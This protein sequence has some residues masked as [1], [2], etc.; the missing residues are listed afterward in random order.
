MQFRQLSDKDWQQFLHWAAL[1]NWRVSFQEQR[2]FQNQWRPYLFA[3]YSNGELCGFV[4]AVAY[5]ESGWIGNLLVPVEQRGK[6]YGSA[7]F[8]HA[9][10]FL[11]QAQPKRIWL[12]ASQSGQPMYER[13]GFEVVD[14]VDR[15][16]TQGQGTAESTREKSVAALVDLDSACWGESRSPLLNALS[17][18]SSICQTGNAVGLLQTGVDAWQLG[19][20]LSAD[21]KVLDNR[22]LLKQAVEKTAAG[23]ELLID[24]LLSAEMDLVLRTSGF[25][26]QGSNQLMVLSAEPPRLNGVMALASLGSIG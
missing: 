1:E 24:V 15:W 11:Q 21:R 6:G 9:L 12:T 13:R 5:K 26:K 16:V 18:D 17:D 8:D 10:Q 3:L 22:Q 23:K 14:R 20:W 2:L 7:L 19:P 25:K 4:S